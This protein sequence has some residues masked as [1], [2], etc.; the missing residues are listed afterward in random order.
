MSNEHS[1][2][3]EL[4]IDNDRYDWD[5]DEINGAQLRELGSVPDDAQ[6][7]QKIPGKPDKP[8]ENDTV[9]NLQDPGPERFSTQPVGSQAG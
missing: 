5:E 9:V 6:I 2:R 7:F 4:F 3:P 8:I 1:N